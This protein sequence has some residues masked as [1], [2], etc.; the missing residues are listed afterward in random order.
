M[1]KLTFAIAGMYMFKGKIALFSDSNAKTQLRSLK[2]IS[3][4]EFRTREE[5]LKKVQEDPNY[6]ILVIGGGATGAGALLSASRKGYKTLLIDSND[7]AAGTSSKS[8]K[9]LHGGLRYLENAFKLRNS[10]RKEDFYL[11]NESLVERDMLLNNV[12]YMNDQVG[13]IIP[14][15]NIFSALFYYGGS[16]FYH[17]LAKAQRYFSVGLMTKSSSIEY[18]F[19]VERPQLI[20]GKGL[21]QMVPMLSK[22]YKYGVILFDGQCDDSALV[23]DAILTATSMNDPSVRMNDAINYARLNEFIKDSTGKITGA[24]IVDKLSGK[25]F[26]VN[27]KVAV[28]ATGVFGDQIKKLANPECETRLAFAKG[29][30]ITLMNDNQEILPHALKNIGVFIPKTS[31]GRVMFLLPWQNSIIAGTTDK[32]V[33]QPVI[34]PFADDASVDEILGNIRPYFPE[35]KFEVVS[36]WSGIRPLVKTLESDAKTKTSLTTYHQTDETSTESKEMS[37]KSSTSRPDAPIGQAE[38]VIP[39]KDLKRVHVIDVD[40]KS[41][42]ITIYGGKLTIFRRMGED[43]IDE[44]S[45]QMLNTGK[46]TQEKF[47]ES[48]TKS[49]GNLRFIGDFRDKLAGDKTATTPTTNIEQSFSDRKSYLD[50][51]TNF[52]QSHYSGVDQD[53]VEYLAKRY[54]HRAIAILNEMNKSASSKLR[55]DPN[56]PYTKAELEHI[57]KSEFVAVP[58]DVLI[59]RLRIAFTDANTTK[60]MLPYVIDIY[61]D[62]HKWDNDRK[63]KEFKESMQILEKMDF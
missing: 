28:N 31:D 12:P 27:F 24:K 9:L 49:T 47:D 6:D 40:D 51:L 42:L 22:D 59:R 37:E 38:E 35:A 58:I 54:G 1:R 29:D 62:L 20:F 34:H 8:T 48:K 56:Y 61:G 46:I 13:M 33:S 3:V 53:I 23:I 7:F 41:G 30:H 55:L 15:T 45:K 10:N 16:W 44:A 11:V 19:Q 4:F 60:K 26:T 2:D 18:P 50:Y 36:K 21:H 52:I 63:R 57:I 14:V 32:V 43:A 25:E 39:T 17:M 5:Q